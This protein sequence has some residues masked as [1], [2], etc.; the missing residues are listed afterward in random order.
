MPYSLGIKI[1]RIC[2]NE[3]DYKTRRQELKAQLRKRGYSG[4][5]TEGQLCKID[6]IPREQLLLYKKKDKSERVPLLLTYSKCLTD[7]S[8]ILCRHMSI[9]HKSE[10]MQ[11]LFREEPMAAYRRDSNLSDMHGKLRRDMPR[12]RPACKA[13][14]RVCTIQAGQ[15]SM[16]TERDVIFGLT[17]TECRK[18]VYVGETE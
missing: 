11:E 9:L 13:D 15:D 1:K 17:C 12:Q 18:V 14:C 3:K 4:K 2:Q 16:C 5:H 6:S 8:K 7:M 10:R